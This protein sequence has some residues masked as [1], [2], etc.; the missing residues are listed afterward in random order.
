MF[1]F[2]NIAVGNRKISMENHRIQTTEQYVV[3]HCKQFSKTQSEREREA[4]NVTKLTV[5]LLKYIL[6]NHKK[7]LHNR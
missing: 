6:L 2:R 4:E 5:V 1:V 7:T 3:I